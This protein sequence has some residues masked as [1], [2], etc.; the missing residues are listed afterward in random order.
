MGGFSYCFINHLKFFSS[1]TSILSVKSLASQI[2]FNIPKNL[3]LYYPQIIDVQ[4]KIHMYLSRIKFFHT[5]I[6]SG[7]IEGTGIS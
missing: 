5:V 1:S 4:S 7:S 2:I 6:H 3:S